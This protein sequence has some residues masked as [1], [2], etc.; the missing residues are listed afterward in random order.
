MAVMLKCPGGGCFPYD[1]LY[2]EG[3]QQ[4][5]RKKETR[6]YSVLSGEPVHLINGTPFPS[7]RN[8]IKPINGE[9]REGQEI[10]FYFSQG[11]DGIALAKTR[12]CELCFKSLVEKWPQR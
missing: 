3:K 8:P 10:G 7:M 12:T 1:C 11:Y 5:E 6:C 9:P 2:V 4:R